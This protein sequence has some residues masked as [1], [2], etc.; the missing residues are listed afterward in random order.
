MRRRADI[1]EENDGEPNEKM[2][3]HGS[4]FIHSIVEKGFDERYSYMGGMFG[5]G[6]SP[7]I[8]YCYLLHLSV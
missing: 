6:I 8:F 1:A 3:Y 7:S 4:P 2:L 5:A